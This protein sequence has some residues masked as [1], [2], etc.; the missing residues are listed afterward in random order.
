MF[1]IA[2]QLHYSASL[3]CCCTVRRRTVK[4]P[5]IFQAELSQHDH[6]LN[7][8]F[9]D[10]CPSTSKA[11]DLDKQKM[12]LTGA[13]QPSRVN[14]LIN[15]VRRP[16]RSKAPRNPL[17]SQLSIFRVRVPMSTKTPTSMQSDRISPIHSEIVFHNYEFSPYQYSGSKC[18]VIS[19]AGR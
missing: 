2:E 12:L 14:I 15:E 3:S 13:N 10:T 11:R 6:L 19:S 18:R 4:S 17:A 7:G 1:N 5:N 16:C 8:E 9:S